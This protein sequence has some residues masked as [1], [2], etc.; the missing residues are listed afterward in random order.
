MLSKLIGIK[1]HPPADDARSLYASSRSDR[2]VIK[3]TLAQ[4]KH[5]ERGGFGV[6]GKEVTRCVGEKTPAG[7]ILLI[8]TACREICF[9]MAAFP[10][11]PQ[12]VSRLHSRPG[13]FQEVQFIF[14]PYDKFDGGNKETITEKKELLCL[15]KNT[16]TQ[17]PMWRDPQKTRA[18]TEEMRFPSK[19]QRPFG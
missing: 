14:E 16:H 10:P 11:P 3:E 7:K 17:Q 19:V 13:W 12:S 4:G 2:R 1:S 15:L 18:L 5:N 6:G 8:E 9:K